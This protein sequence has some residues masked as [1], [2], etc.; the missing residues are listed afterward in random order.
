MIGLTA[1]GGLQSWVWCFAVGPAGLPGPTVLCLF[2]NGSSLRLGVPSPLSLLIPV[3][4]DSF[5]FSIGTVTLSL[6]TGKMSAK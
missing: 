4:S 5:S 2:E 6:A 3:W 1:R